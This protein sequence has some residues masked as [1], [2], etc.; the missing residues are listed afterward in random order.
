MRPEATQPVG[1]VG[2][3]ATPLDRT[4][5]PLCL[6]TVHAHPDDEASKGSATVARYSDEGVRTVLVCCTGGEAGEILNPAVDTPEMRA[7]LARVRME[8]LERAAAAI[9]YSAVYRLGYHDSGMP[10]SE[11]N[12]RPDNFANAP[13]DEAVERLVRIIRAERPQVVVT[14]AEDREF[15]PHPDHIRVHEISVPA[16]EAAGDPDAFPDAGAPWQPSKLYYTGFSRR[17]VEALHDEFLRRGEESPYA[18]WFERP[19][20]EHAERYTTFVEVGDWLHRRRAALLAHRTQVDPD[21]FWMRL[22]DDVIRRVFPWE[23][24][25]LARSLV[26][27]GVPDGDTEDDLFAGVRAEA[28]VPRA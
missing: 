24:F 27:T 15:Y 12:A 14:Y 1:I 10:D 5:F 11:H 6:L 3:V 16:F 22:P 8:E 21:G 19:L 20:P 4:G 18:R 2:D 7:D 26:E 9:G 13:L 17:R 23:E 28:V 25:L